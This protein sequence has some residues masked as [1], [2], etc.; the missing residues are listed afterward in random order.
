M[1]KYLDDRLIK[2]L[3]LQAG[4]EISCEINSYKSCSYFVLTFNIYFLIIGASSSN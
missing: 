2:T 3:W 1:E 4:T